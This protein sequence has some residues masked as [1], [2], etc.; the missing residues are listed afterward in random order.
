MSSAF[1]MPATIAG[2]HTFS[3]AVT[4]SDDLNHDGA[5]VGFFGTTPTTAAGAVSDF[6]RSDMNGVN[7][8][9]QANL[10]A[11]LDGIGARLAAIIDAL[12]RHGL[13]GA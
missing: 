12:Q 10:E 2:A 9:N 11:D 3:G 13:M 8:V 1:T 5:G 4:L 7:P 6:A